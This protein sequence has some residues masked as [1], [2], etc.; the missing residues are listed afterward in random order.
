MCQEIKLHIR[1]RAL[2]LRL[3]RSTRI[4]STKTQSSISQEQFGFRWKNSSFTCQTCQREVLEMLPCN[5]TGC[6]MWQVAALL[7]NIHYKREEGLMWSCDQF[8]LDW[9]NM[10][11][12]FQPC[13]CSESAETFDFIKTSKKAGQTGVCKIQIAKA[14]D[15]VVIRLL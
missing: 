4:E 13:S 9:V 1:W 7:G 15:A 10:K 14:E 6:L 11:S 12:V 8:D 2:R 5:H 3:K